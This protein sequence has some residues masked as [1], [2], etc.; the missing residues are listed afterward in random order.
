MKPYVSFSVFNHDGGDTQ[1]HP[2]MRLPIVL[3]SMSNVLLIAAG[4]IKHGASVGCEHTGRIICK[5][6]TDQVIA[7][8]MLDYRENVPDEDDVDGWPILVEWVCAS[9]KEDL[10]KLYEIAKSHSDPARYSA[11]VR[12]GSVNVSG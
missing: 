3:S 10:G 1:T 5:D 4:L 11:K 2:M 12:H 8:V 6:A 9:E 7:E